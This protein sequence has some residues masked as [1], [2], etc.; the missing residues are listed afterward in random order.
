[1]LN[2][3]MTGMCIGGA[4]IAILWNEKWTWGTYNRCLIAGALL[5]VAMNIMVGW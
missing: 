4:I 1:M 2:G 3:V 5:A